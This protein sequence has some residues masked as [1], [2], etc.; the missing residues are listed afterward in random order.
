MPGLTD[1][2]LNAV[3]LTNEKLRNDSEIIKGIQS[4]R[5]ADMDEAIRQQAAASE[6]GKI[7][8]QA[9]GTAKLL[10]QDKI[11]SQTTALGTNLDDASQVMTALSGEWK[12]AALDSVEASKRVEKN[13]NA[14][15]LD[16]PI[17]YV[18]AQLDL[19]GSVNA[20]AAVEN[21]KAVIQNSL[22]FAQ[23]QT[24]QIVVTQNALT[25]TASHETVQATIEQAEAIFK[26]KAAQQ[27]VENAGIN[28]DGIRTLNGLTLQEINNMSTA[29][30]AKSQEAHLELSRAQ[31]SQSQKQFQLMMEERQDRI[32]QKKADKQEQEDFADVIRKGAATLGYENVKAFPTSKIIQLM[33]MKAPGFN[34]YLQ[35]G[36]KTTVTSYP[37]VNEDAGQSA[38]II[39]Q[40][41]A[42]LRPEQKSIKQFFT[43]VWADASSPA[44]GV[45]GGYDNTKV[46]AVSK[47]AGLIAAR[48]AEMFAKEIKQGDNSNIYAPPPLEAVTN[49]P[50]V[51]SSKFYKSV[52]EPQFIGGGLKELNPEQVI[53]MAAAAVKA[54]QITYAEAAQGVQGIFNASVLVNNTTKNY[55]G[56]GLPN[57]RGFNTR[58]E[59]GFGNPR[60]YDLTQPAAVNTLLSS[61][62]SKFQ[63]VS[64]DVNAA[65]PFGF[66]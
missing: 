46:D 64:R 32:L 29:L 21:R 57:Q 30:S 63:S 15:F 52:L 47:A 50:A 27:R 17:A 14:K 41:G 43:S 39:A 22:T 59:S 51:K 19:E 23:Q 38:R 7:I 3:G 24:Q 11:V 60:M 61:R 18:K 49:I 28:I 4:Q 48:Q 42:P 1:E 54:K 2:L 13:V 37:V 65:R 25:K 45:K 26:S 31:F 35:A 9:E 16:D 36:M 34:D 53:S 10:T 62:L 66:N 33:S 40:T 55:L 12:K 44:S 5:Q 20:A 6:A 58:V 8:I 56:Y